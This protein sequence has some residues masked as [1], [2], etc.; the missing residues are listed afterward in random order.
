[1]TTIAK[2][3]CCLVLGLTIWF[4]PVP[5]GLL[6][7]AWH[8]F[9]IFAAVIFA[10]I[11]GAMP[12]VLA[13]LL[14]LVTSI[15]TGTLQPKEAYAGFGE[16]LILLIVAAFLVGR[17]VVNSGLGYRLAYMLVRRF[18]S[19]SLGLAYRFCQQ[20]GPRRSFVSGGLCLGAE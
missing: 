17:G 12:I 8:L 9:A 2:R 6:P 19:S 1:M 7:Q 16:G 5:V 4:A 11:I 15:L 10:V 18:G 20:Y 14:G 13:S 3:F